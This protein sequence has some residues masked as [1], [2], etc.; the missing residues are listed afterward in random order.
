MKEKII[1]IVDDTQKNI[2]LL[3]Q[4]L[5]PIGYRIIVAMNGK[6]ALNAIEIQIPDLILM[7]INMPEMDGFETTQKIKENEKLKSIPIIFLTARADSV[8]I[9]KGFEYGGADYITKPFNSKE[10]LTRISYQIELKEQREELIRINSENRQLL[11]VLLH[12]LRNP[13]GVVDVMCEMLKTKPEN[14]EKIITLI[15]QATKNCMNILDNVRTMFSLGDNKY[16]PQ[17]VL[18]NIKST[19][20]SS[21]RIFEH[22]F[23]SKG[24]TVE[25]DIP[26]GLKAV[27]D[28][29][30][31]TDSVFN[32]L[33]TNA[34]K[35][36]YADSKIVIAAKEVGDKVLLSVQDFGIGIPSKILENIFDVTKST[37]RSGTNGE[38]GTGY[39]MPLVKKFVE[40]SKARIEIKSIE[41]P[42]PGHGTQVL[43]Y[44]EKKLT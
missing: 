38:K 10:L 33:I 19:I 7:D 12:D 23:N 17:L 22:Q 40:L 41:K 43:V 9:L 1:L 16:I 8:D 21:L 13:V 37:S 35:F 28:G 34:I 29:G 26:D 25:I 14:Q 15:T 11:R 32:N 4:I 31:F 36:S 24:L 20:E 30:S 5:T 2:Q 3:G 39:G 42:N 18:F 27:A 6:Q 44:L